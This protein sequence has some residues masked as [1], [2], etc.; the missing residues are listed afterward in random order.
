MSKVAIIGSGPAGYTAGIYAAR[1]NLEPVLFEG[2]ESGGQL[3]LTTDVENYPG[4]VDGIMGPE[5]MQVFKQQAER[6]G[7]VIKTEFIDSIEKTDEGFKLK[8]S[9]EEYM[10]DTV[11]LAPGASARWLG[12]KGEK[13]LQGYGVSACATCDGFFFKEKTVAVVGGGDSAME[14]ALFLT[15]FAT[16]VIVIHR[17]DEFRAS[18]IMQDRVLNHDQIEVMW[19][20]TV[21]EIKGDGAVSSVVLK[22]AQDEST[23]EVN[24][25]GVFVAIGHDPN[26]KFLDGLVEL[27]EK[28]ISKQG[29]VLPPVLQLMESLQLE[30][31][32]IQFIDKQSLLRVAVVRLLL[33]LK[34]GWI[35]KENNLDYLSKLTPEEQ[36][37]LEEK[38]LSAGYPKPKDLSELTSYIDLF[39]A[40]YS[41][42]KQISKDDLWLEL[43]NQ[44]YKLGDRILN[45]SSPY[46]K[47]SDV[48]ELQELLSRLGFY[49]DPINSE[50]TKSLSSAVK[51]FQENRGLIA[52]GIVG[53]ETALEI[54]SLVRPNLSTSLNEAIKTFRPSQG[55]LSVAIYVDNVGEYREQVVFYEQLKEAC[56]ELGFQVKFVSEID[57][58]I[59]EENVSKYVNKLSPHLFLIF[60]H[61]D[62]QT[63]NYFQGK[64]SESKIGKNISENLSKKIDAEIAGKNSYLLKNTRAVAVNI[65]G[66]FYQYS[67]FDVLQIIKQTFESIF[68]SN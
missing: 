26:I 64:H 58:E 38:L 28:V 66:N 15:K 9:K 61:S 44:G 32:L 1:A 5:L 12:V 13:E 17:R 62:N 37:D 10:F 21:E 54:K 52:D 8:S 31:L 11:I 48:E 40:D 20:K 16:K 18:Q 19:N 46:L 53:L 2:L 3:M 51:D 14:E 41:L 24:L 36:T 50:Y 67:S 34:D 35:I 7:T 43:L 47:G 60:K 55:L 39:L 23:E 4:F 45:L 25:D 42:D 27:D 6:F 68:E 30:M 63:I 29:L 56:I 49:S 57:E 22:D 65:N 33:M 59:S